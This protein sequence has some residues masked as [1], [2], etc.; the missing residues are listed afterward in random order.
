MAR[1][2]TVPAASLHLLPLDVASVPGREG[3]SELVAHDFEGVGEERPIASTLH[4]KSTRRL[5]ALRPII[6]WNR[7]PCFSSN[8]LIHSGIVR[9]V[10]PHLSLIPILSLIVYGCPMHVRELHFITARKYKGIY[11]IN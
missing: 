5:Y 2:G 11:K 8:S 10:I 6:T 7:K 1:F 4:G 3:H 9:L